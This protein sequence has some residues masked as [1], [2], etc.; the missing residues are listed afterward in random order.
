M[1]LFTGLAWGAGESKSS[2]SRV[3]VC[4]ADV[5]RHSQL[6]GT[7]GLWARNTASQGVLAIWSEGEVGK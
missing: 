5:R 7:E 1:L 2:R 3:A 6:L 4:R